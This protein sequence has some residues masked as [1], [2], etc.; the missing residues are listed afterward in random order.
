MGNPDVYW[1]CKLLLKVHQRILTHHPAVN[2]VDTQRKKGRDR[3]PT[4]GCPT[5]KKGE[6]TTKK[7]FTK[8][9][10]EKRSEEETQH[11]PG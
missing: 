5:Y 10:G 4:K 7:S 6:A 9:N 2:R 11:I 1:L 3:G 8:Q